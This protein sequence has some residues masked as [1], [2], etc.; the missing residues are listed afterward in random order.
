MTRI[1]GHCKGKTEPKSS[2]AEQ[3]EPDL[4]VLES[5]GAIFCSIMM[6]EEGFLQ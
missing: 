2:A 1:P 6:R 4:S 3:P 5:T